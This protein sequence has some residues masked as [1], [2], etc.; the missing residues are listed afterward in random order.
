[1]DAVAGGE[2]AGAAVGKGF[3]GGLAVQP[4]E[5]GAEGLLGQ[6]QEGRE[7]GGGEQGREVEGNAGAEGGGDGLAVAVG[8]VG[9]RRSV[10]PGG[11]VGLAASRSR[12]RPAGSVAARRVSASMPAARPAQSIELDPGGSSSTSR[13]ANPGS[14]LTSW[15]ATSA[16]REWPTRSSTAGRGDPDGSAPTVSATS[17]ARS[18]MESPASVRGLAP[19]PRRSTARTRYPRSAR[20]AP[21]RHQV[22]DDDV[23]PCTSTARGRR[24]E[25]LWTAPRPSRPAGLPSRTGGPGNGASGSRAPGVAPGVPEVKAP[26]GPGNR[27]A[28]SRAPGA[29]GAEAPAA[30]APHSLV[31]RR[32]N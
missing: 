4:G 31:A 11:Q 21:T 12:R 25:G 2:D 15:R 19:C 24:L 3:D 7:R 18:A 9:D 32:A 10:S 14:T 30:P 13:R 26:E 29:P 8:Q 28:G 23:T 22:R 5:V 17:A 6:E 1:V 16:P 27:I 20:A